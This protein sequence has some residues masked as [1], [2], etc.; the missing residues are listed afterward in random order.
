MLG[1]YLKHIKEKTTRIKTELK[2]KDDKTSEMHTRQMAI[3]V[4]NRRF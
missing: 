3:R 1:V 2:W 4:F